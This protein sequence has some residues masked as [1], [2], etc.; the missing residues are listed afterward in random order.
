[1][2]TG[3]GKP[4]DPSERRMDPTRSDDRAERTGDRGREPAEPRTPIWWFPSDYDWFDKPEPRY[5]WPD[6]SI[7][8]DTGQPEQQPEPDSGPPE[9]QPPVGEAEED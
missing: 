4:S 8:E 3:E 5:L 7:S 9:E 6:G 1:M 2:D